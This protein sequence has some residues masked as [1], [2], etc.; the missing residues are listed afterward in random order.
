MTDASANLD[1]FNAMAAEWDDSPLRAGIARAVAGAIADTLPL[2]GGMRALEYGC[3]TGLVSVLLA[4]RLGHIV[5]ADVAPAMLDVLD[6]KCRRAGLSNIEPRR[7]DLTVD[8]P[9]AERFDLVFSSMTLHHIEDVPALLGTLT[10]MLAAGGWLALA[11]LDR[12]DGGF[13]GGP[14]PGVFHLG[15]ERAWLMDRLRDLGLDDV[16]A[17]TAHV[18]R[19]PGPDGMPRDYPI[20]LATARRV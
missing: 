13:H 5:A 20:F 9:P 15:F 18:A 11:D 2:H 10:Q 14:M 17:R 12:E 1:R 8:P 6:A 7:L 19:K 16:T 4:D 3:G